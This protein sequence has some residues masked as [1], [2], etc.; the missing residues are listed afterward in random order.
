MDFLVLVPQTF[1]N[2]VFLP[3]LQNYR[4]L[5]VMFFM[6]TIRKQ[7]QT[8][9]YLPLVSMIL[10]DTTRRQRPTF[11]PITP[12]SP[13]NQ[14]VIDTDHR[15][16]TPPDIQTQ[17]PSESF[18]NTTGQTVVICRWI[19][20]ASMLMMFDKEDKTYAGEKP[21]APFSIFPVLL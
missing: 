6:F 5:C 1:V 4:I 12:W 20:T 2:C 10:A 21:Y 3:I 14:T 9:D 11:I 17:R 13:G 7:K 18:E 16:H 8:W 19:T 15:L